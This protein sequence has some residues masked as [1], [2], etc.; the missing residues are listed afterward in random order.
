MSGI[1]PVEPAAPGGDPHPAPPIAE[2][3]AT[4][5]APETLT[6]RAGDPDS[7]GVYGRWAALPRRTRRTALTLAGAVAAIA[8]GCSLLLSRPAPPASPPPPWPAQAVEVSYA[9]TTDL[10]G[11]ANDGVFTFRIRVAAVRNTAVTVENIA[12]PYPALSL[13][14]SPRTPV[15]IRSG[16]SRDLTVRISVRHCSGIPLGVELPPLDVT[17]RNIRAIKDQTFLI[18]D[19]YANDLSAALRARCPAH[20]SRVPHTP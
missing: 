6:S 18:G 9:G 14:T 1:G 12:Q 2:A 16:T 15:T 7:P 3:P 19:A 17:L 5:P 11:A 13:I 8:T 20:R 10:D 4:G